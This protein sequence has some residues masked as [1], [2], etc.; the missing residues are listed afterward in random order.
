MLVLGSICKKIIILDYKKSTSSLIFF[1][2]SGTRKIILD[3][4]A[5][6]GLAV[7]AFTKSMILYI[8]FICKCIHINGTVQLSY[9]ID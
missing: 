6:K 5:L 2:L 3:R 4:I 1:L 7:N 9:E 8:S